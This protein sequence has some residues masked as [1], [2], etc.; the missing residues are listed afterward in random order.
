MGNANTHERRKSGGAPD[1]GPYI[2]DIRSQPDGEIDEKTRKGSYDERDS[3]SP[4]NKSKTPPPSFQTSPKEERGVEELPESP[5]RPDGGFRPR[6]GTGVEAKPQEASHVLPT[7]IK[8]SGAA[9]EVYVCGTFSEWAKI[10]MVKS[11]KDFVA[12]IDLPV[13]EHQYKFMVDGQMVHD[14]NLPTVNTDQGDKNNYI[15]IQQGDF[16]AFSA[17][18]M[19]SKSTNLRH[20]RGG[21]RSWGQDI[22]NIHSFDNKA[23]PPVLPPH[24]LQVILNKDTPLSCEP[25]LL[26]EPNHAM[27]NHLYALSIKDGVMVISS[28]QRYRKKYVTTLLYKPIEGAS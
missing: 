17:L 6:A 7:I 24:L 13:G 3:E 9:K 10:P 14:N 22:P 1:A 20:R 15:Q 26:P 8:Y 2:E 11:Q 25:T 12:L 18:D 28:T 23:G 5:V 21:E 19:D 27:I 16:D 4:G